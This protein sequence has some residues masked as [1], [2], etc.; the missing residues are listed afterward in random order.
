[1]AEVPKELREM[2]ENQL[3]QRT[4]SSTVPVTVEGEWGIFENDARLGIL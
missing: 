3:G 2:E 1:M 4:V